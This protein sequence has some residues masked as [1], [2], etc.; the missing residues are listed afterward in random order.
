MPAAT[1]LLEREEELAT[2]ERVLEAAA[3]G[4]GG[5]LAIEGEAG[6]GKTTL[7]QAAA[8]R[9]AEREMLVLRAR[10]GEY[11]RDF[12]Y[13]V[14]R[15]LFE[16]LLVEPGR[17]EELLSRDAASA[18]PVF[19]PAA[20]P[21]AGADPFAVQHG[22]HRLVSALAASAPLL[23]LVDDAQ[24]A[25]LASLRALTYVGRRIEELPAV[26][27]LTV[28]TGEPGEHEALLNELRRE[29]AAQSVEPSPLSAAAA[30]TLVEGE[31]GR[32]PSERFALA[33]CD[34]TAGNPFLLVELLRAIDPGEMGTAEADAER[35]AEVAAAGTSRS[36]LSRLARL[37]DHSTAVARAVA[38]LEPNAEARLIAALTTLSADAVAEA[39]ERLVI[40][41]LLS[42]SQP[43][44]FV[45]PLVREAVLSEVPAPRRAADHARAARLLSDDGA[46]ADT[47]A[48]QLLL[49]EPRGDGWAVAALRDAAAEA[50]GRGAPEA[51][52]SY[53]RRALREP[54]PKQDRLEVSRELGV[55]L[56]RADEP[57]GIEVL[58]AV[59]SSLRDPVARA[60]IT[61][62]LSASLAL[63]RPGGE[64][65]VLLE[66]SLA[67]LPDHRSDLGLQLRGHVLNQV[68]SGLEG[69]P[70]G[71]LP[72]PDEKLDTEAEA[73]RLLLM[74]VAFLY[75]I[76]LGSMNRVAALA[77]WVV[78][79]RAAAEAAALAGRPPQLALLTLMLADYEYPI[80]LFDLMIEASKRRG[81]SPGVAS[82][83]GVRAICRYAGGELQE[84]LADADTALR[85]V[86]PTGIRVGLANWLSVAVR[87]LVALGEPAMAQDLLD[88]VWRGRAPGPGIPGATLLVSRGEL[89]AASDRHAE[90]R[91][92]YLAA[93][94]RVRWVP[95][96][97]PEL[98]GWRTGLA[99]AEAALG[100]AEEAQRLAGEAV[101]LARKAGGKR[102]IGIAL[103]ALGA[104][105]SG[106][107]GIELLGEASEVL[108]GTHAK[109]EHS[110]ALADLGA[111]LRRANKRKEARGPLREALDLASRFGAAALEQRVRTE[112]AAT[113]ARPR[114]AVLS[115][116]ES[117]T[118]SELRVAQMAAD[119]MT[120]PQ[121]AHSLVVSRKT[122]ETHMRHVFQKLDIDRRTELADRLAG[123]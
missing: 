13:G 87:T 2:I 73:G 36:I 28:R 31:V 74:E 57:E 79:D 22:L 24:W 107:E 47:V 27:A 109:L 46:D 33:C 90:A 98:L 119:G 10:G 58:R 101:G 86:R 110:Y 68:M 118:P 41:R 122:V 105:A 84:S 94:E 104:V 75:A 18:V 99:R 77:D 51:A 93:A 55:A 1:A 81:T 30:A 114:K 50:L 67:E 32:Q 108:A 52:V 116:V 37:G 83:F 106:T 66:E 21:V 23:M 14:V 6:A 120:N 5:L 25:D 71:I 123:V 89:R 11:E 117:L 96:A 70:E 85:L 43:L 38:V 111:A 19:E 63:R 20:A 69:V 16:P 3:G 26:L 59:R 49:A 112:L 54:P 40:A 56:L 44:A 39:S 65:V 61:V 97:N 45:H 80:D 53:L 9:G 72:G 121:I 103:A 42:D 113:G 12:P 15:Q 8:R 64:G 95:Y 82:G 78:S 7:L 29:P 62:E 48:A 76:G 102:G 100:N 35:L 17:R 115:G 4:D 60:E 88:E 34:A 92:D 91:H